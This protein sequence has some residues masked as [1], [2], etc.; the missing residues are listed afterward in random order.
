MSD[1]ERR[2]QD[3]F[4]RRAPAYVTSRSHSDQSLLSRVVALARPNQRDRVLDV[5]TGT[6]H[7]AFA[8]APY[9][10]EVIG[11]DITVEMIVEAKRL[12]TQRGLENVS[13]A[14][15]SAAQLP[16]DGEAFHIVTCRRSAHHFSNIMASLSEMN[17][18]LEAGGRLI[19]DDRSVPE[20]DFVDAT[21]NRLDELHDESHVRE[22][23]LSEWTNMLMETSF[24]PEAASMYSEH[25]PLSSLTAQVAPE[26][27]ARIQAII[28]GLNPQQ[29]KAM[30][31]VE[32]DGQ[33]FT[34]HWFV[35]LSATKL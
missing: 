15:A 2:A 11:I 5:A 19:V 16:F 32:R 29:R 1:R 9:V 34:D 24:R 21:M 7:T 6:G 22:Y 26:R 33:I 3:V 13:L 30:N 31:A 10:S 12:R 4:G 18:V 23:R 27:V 14:L 20:D 17:R 35:M 8:F 28:E 25:R